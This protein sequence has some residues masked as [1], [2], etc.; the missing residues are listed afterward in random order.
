MP[1]QHIAAHMR[2]RPNSV[3]EAKER[4]VKIIGYFPGNYVP[5]EII[6]AS[7]AIPLC[8]ADGGTPRPADIALSVLPNII[9]P[10]ARAQVGERLLKTNPYYEMLDMIVAPITCQHLKKVA[11]VLE[12]TD[13]IEILKLGVP[14]KYDGDRE[15]EYYAG[16]LMTLKERLQVFTGRKITNE[17]ISEAIRLYNRMRGLLENISLLRRKPSPPLSALDF[18]KLNHASFYSDPTFM[19]HVLDSLYKE[20]RERQTLNKP[21][22]P[23]LLLTGPNLAHGDYRILELVEAAGGD[24]VIEEV[25]EGMRHYWQQVEMQGDPVQ[26]LAKAYLRDR[27]P[28]SAFMRSSTRKRLDFNLK[29]IGDFNVSGVIWYELL[30]CETYDQES[31]FFEQK[32][33]AQN[34]PMLL[35]ES[36][37][38][39][40]D[41]GPLRTRV[42]AF[43]ELVKGGPINA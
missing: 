36:D 19:V 26:S 24:V 30:C 5:E 32:M 11:E 25:Y 14:H 28:H 29:L 3:R 34:I 33:R 39:V 7:G 9:C 23:R 17:R 41:A 12:Y 31:Y 8:L 42:D 13:D 22:R 16:R 38:N 35:V 10:F 4:G 1:D 18:A 37:Y 43:I 6:Y 2:D 20:L 40:S 15:L 21:D 27:V